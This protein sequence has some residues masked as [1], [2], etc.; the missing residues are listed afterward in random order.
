M[1]MVDSMSED[2]EVTD[3]DAMNGHGDH[4]DMVMSPMDQQGD[5]ESGSPMVMMGSQSM[6]ISMSG[7]IYILLAKFAFKIA[8][9]HFMK[10]AAIFFL[11]IYYLNI[12][13]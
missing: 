4:Q 1:E 3:S 8:Y 5:Q 12:R 10:C 2:V 11:I 6:Y 7:I 13:S 9:F